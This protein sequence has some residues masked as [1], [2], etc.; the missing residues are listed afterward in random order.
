MAAAVEK[1][2]RDTAE[3]TPTRKERPR[4]TKHQQSKQRVQ[5]QRKP[6]A[7]P[8][9]TSK[10][11]SEPQK[12]R[13]SFDSKAIVF[14]LN[15]WN[16]K[17]TSTD[18]LQ[19]ENE[20]NDDKK[21]QPHPS[22]LKTPAASTS[23]S[24]GDSSKMTPKTIA[25]NKSEVIPMSPMGIDGH[26]VGGSRGDG[27][28]PPTTQQQVKVVKPFA[29][30][31]PLLAATGGAPRSNS[32]S[33]SKQLPSNIVQLE[34]ALLD[35]TSATTSSSS[36]STLTSPGRQHQ[37]QQ[38]LKNKTA[39]QDRQELELLALKEKYVDAKNKMEKM[40]HEKETNKRMLLE[41][42][43][44]VKGL[45]SIATRTTSTNSNN[46]NN[47]TDVVPAAVVQ[48]QIQAIDRQ[49]KQAQQQC[50][51]LLEVKST[52]TQT[53]HKQESRIKLMERQILDLV[54]Q[55]EEQTNVS[56]RGQTDLER[57][58]EQQESQIRA[59][60]QQ[61]AKTR[62]K[63][64]EEEEDEGDEDDDIVD[65]DDDDD[66]IA[67]SEERIEQ[68]DHEIQELVAK[69][70]QKYDEINQLQ[71]KLEALRERQKAHLSQFDGEKVDGS[72]L[73]SEAHEIVHVDEEED[74]EVTVRVYQREE[75]PPELPLL[76]SSSSPLSSPSSKR[77]KS[78]SRRISS[79]GSNSS[80]SRSSQGGSR[81]ATPSLAVISENGESAFDSRDSEVS[82]VSRSPPVATTAVTAD[83]SMMT[84]TTASTPS[85]AISSSASTSSS[86]SSS[87][88]ES[89]SG[90]SASQT[91]Q[92][93]DDGGQVQVQSKELPLKKMEEKSIYTA[94]DE[95]SVPFADESQHSADSTAVSYVE[96]DEE[97]VDVVDEMIEEIIEAV[98]AREVAAAPIEEKEDEKCEFMSQ[99]SN[100]KALLRKELDQ[101]RAKFAKLKEDYHS[102]VFDSNEKV[103]KLEKENRELRQNN[104]VALSSMAQVAE[105]TARSEGI[106]EENEQL[107]KD[108]EEL[109]ARSKET[110]E[111]YEKLQAEQSKSAKELE[112]TTSRYDQLVKDYE[113][114]AHR[115][116]IVESYERQEQIHNITV[117]KLADMSDDNDALTK[118]LDA[119][120]A[121]LQ[122]AFSDLQTYDE[123]SLELKKLKISHQELEEEHDATKIQVE[124]LT[125]KY[126]SLKFKYDAKVNTKSPEEHQKLQLAYSDALARIE[127]LE[128]VHEE[129]G[130]AEA[131]LGVSAV[132]LTMQQ[133]EMEKISEKS[134]ALENKLADRESQM[135]DLIA[136]YKEIK[137]EN[138][139]LC[140]KLEKAEVLITELEKS[141]KQAESLKSTAVATE[142]NE[143]KAT[144]LASK[145]QIMELEKERNDA[146]EKMEAMETEISAVKEEATAAVEA[147]KARE[148]DMRIVLSH[149]KKLLAKYEEKTDEL[150]ELTQSYDEVTKKI[151]E[152]EKAAAEAKDETNH[153]RTTASFS[154]GPNTVPVMSTLEYLYDEEKKEDEEEQARS[155][156]MTRPRRVKEV[157]ASAS[158][159]PNLEMKLTMEEE[160]IIEEE[161]LVDENGDEIIE[162]VISQCGTKSFEEEIIEDDGSPIHEQ[163]ITVLMDELNSSRHQVDTLQAEKN[164]IQGELSEVK[165]Q[166]LLAK[167]R[168]TAATSTT[169]NT[170]AAAEDGLS[171]PD[172]TNDEEE[173]S[174]GYSSSNKNVTQSSD[175]LRDA[176][177]KHRRL[178]QLYDSLQ[179]R[180]NKLEQDLAAA[181]KEAK[182]REEEAKGAGKRAS[183]VHSQHKLLQAEHTTVLQRLEKAEQKL[184]GLK[185]TEKKQVVVQPAEIVNV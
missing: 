132:K 156:P 82:P 8:W 28:E 157:S 42:S 95:L 91:Q 128:R 25:I 152:L 72:K 60:E 162:E 2:S 16:D 122:K 70:A 129:A 85:T 116:T 124:R 180:Y 36:S 138:A 35:Q 184:Q 58:V 46:N 66:S 12:K 63:Q 137:K 120:K 107:R 113:K 115:T 177:A 155:S 125:E 176:V 59:L 153:T 65:D 27:R 52:Q 90:A 89:S 131:K 4:Q 165:S 139:K 140:T 117:M 88:W 84:R 114:V 80:S 75:S 20:N 22:I 34:Q 106:R 99:E 56:T 154:I 62:K 86:A 182:V 79:S 172:G 151:V 48:S 77:K 159:A 141:A 102:A 17:S 109:K 160:E 37:N 73:T 164:R 11:Q 57:V 167:H 168:A 175:R 143:L 61:I 163:K 68:N 21:P 126:G 150:H 74:G 31:V 19:C 81:Q 30:R 45:Q 64:Q 26:S 53:I 9:S 92:L 147:K 179:S 83:A 55:L 181:K 166:L 144:L 158:A 135:K 38:Q 108:L 173:D 41:M 7:F 3:E 49:M 47:K 39:L 111:K 93:N 76:L 32:N 149:H 15:R 121:Q 33:Q 54:D 50:G 136:Q 94:D 100:S 71:S 134:K 14:E 51:I 171:Q 69:N 23:T 170:A 103:G 5:V 130:D 98:E 178:Q 13:V 10:Q 169:T 123:T 133:T 87:G 118:E 18:E 24:S 146:F 174:M 183:M 40:K 29:G 142:I 6:R 105:V 127:Y 97:S 104:I 185:T 44:L 43:R 145:G 110:N 112:L 67:A 96:K 1:S 78:N 119:T 101:A 148:N 161:V